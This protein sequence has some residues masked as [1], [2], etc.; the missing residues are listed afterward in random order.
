MTVTP[1]G[2]CSGRDWGSRPMPNPRQ[3]HPAHATIDSRDDFVAGMGRNPK[4][5]GHPSAWGS[6]DPQGCLQFSQPHPHDMPQS[7]DAPPLAFIPLHQ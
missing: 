7:P 2:E 1:A 3:R 6:P 4:R 5:S